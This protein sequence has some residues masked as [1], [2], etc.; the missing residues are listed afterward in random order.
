L[1]IPGE[2]NSVWEKF[3]P[4]PYFAC[5]KLVSRPAA[6]ERYIDRS[7]VMEIFDRILRLIG[8]VFVFVK[9]ST[10]L[11]LAGKILTQNLGHIFRMGY[12]SERSFLLPKYAKKGSI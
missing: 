11:K 5:E 3:C 6:V 4:N 9:K 10:I 12:F 1:G 8:R 2:E 7:E